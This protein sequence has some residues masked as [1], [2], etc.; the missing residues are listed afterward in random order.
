MLKPIFALKAFGI[1]WGI[2]SAS[3][4]ICRCYY[5]KPS[6]QETCHF[7]FEKKYEKGKT[8]QELISHQLKLP[9]SGKFMRFYDSMYLYNLNKKTFWEADFINYHAI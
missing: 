6:L 3:A 9:L 7:A 5:Y 8:Q 2:N 1:F 4:S